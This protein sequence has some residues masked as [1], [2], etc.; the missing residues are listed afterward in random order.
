MTASATSRFSPV[1]LDEIVKKEWPGNIRELRSTVRRLCVFGEER[2]TESGALAAS[3]FSAGESRQP[4]L[5][6]YLESA[7]KEYILKILADNNG[8]VGRAHGVLGLSRKGL[9]DK[10]N[11]YRI[12]LEMLKGKPGS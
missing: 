4:S 2:E 11:K 3:D 10:I 8:K 6:A 9:Y 12:D 1:Q 5:K 7:E